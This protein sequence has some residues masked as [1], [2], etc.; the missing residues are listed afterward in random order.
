MSIRCSRQER[1]A[2]DDGP[3][4]DHVDHRHGLFCPAPQVGARCG[5]VQHRDAGTAN[6]DALRG[7]GDVDGGTGEHC[8]GIAVVDAGGCQATGDAAG[9][10]VHLSPGG[11]FTGAW[12]SPV[13]IPFMLRR[14]FRNI[15]SVNWLTEAP[16]CVCA[17][18]PGLQVGLR[19]AG[20][21]V[22]CCL[23]LAAVNDVHGGLLG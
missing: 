20:L 19:R 21:P 15:V 12:G 23:V 4:A 22:R 13:I 14:A 2:D 10:F 18:A 1:L 3:G 6:P 11:C 5:L 16:R 9:A 17:K 7:G 8:H